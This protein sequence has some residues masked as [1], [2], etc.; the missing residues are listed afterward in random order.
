MTLYVLQIW[1]G[2]FKYIYIMFIVT[3]DFVTFILETQYRHRWF[4]LKGTC[5]PML[6][7]IGSSEFE[8]STQWYDIILSNCKKITDATLCKPVNHNCVSANVTAMVYKNRP[9]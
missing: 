1:K 6:V 7:L 8:R 5:K 4:L 3:M 9:R 2:L